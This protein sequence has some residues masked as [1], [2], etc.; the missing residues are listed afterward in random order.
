MGGSGGGQ[1]TEETG[2][3][4]LRGT[5]DRRDRWTVLQKG[6]WKMVR[7]L[8]DNV[9]DRLR[10]LQNEK[11]VGVTEMDG[12]RALGPK[13]GQIKGPIGRGKSRIRRTGVAP[14]N[15]HVRGP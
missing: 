5:I 14:R 11:V 15:G 1:L 7:A 12:C 6:L 13:K 10:T 8:Q 3:R 9:L 2:G 4:A